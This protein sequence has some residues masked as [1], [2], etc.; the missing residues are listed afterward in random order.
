MVQFYFCEWEKRT[1]LWL[2]ELEWNFFLIEL[3]SHFFNAKV[4]GFQMAKIRKKKMEKKIV[5]SE[6]KNNFMVRQ[7]WGGFFSI[8]M[9]L[10]CRTRKIEIDIFWHVDR[11]MILTEFLAIF[12]DFKAIYTLHQVPIYF[13]SPIKYA[14]IKTIANFLKSTLYKMISI[15]LCE[16][17]T[18]LRYFRGFSFKDTH[19]GVKFF[20]ESLW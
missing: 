14:I 10:F 5:M 8:V 4:N 6:K 3:Q 16:N 1:M 11:E 2:Y 13:F 15:L 9:F 17:K 12:S 20:W 7:S 19:N 18:L